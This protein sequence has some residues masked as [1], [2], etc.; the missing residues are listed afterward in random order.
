MA[1]RSLAQRLPPS[2][3]RPQYTWHDA[4]RAAC[5][6]RSGSEAPAAVLRVLGMCTDADTPGISGYGAGMRTHTGSTTPL[7]NLHR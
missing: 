2:G 5:Q 3:P 1:E 4:A 7:L 6:P